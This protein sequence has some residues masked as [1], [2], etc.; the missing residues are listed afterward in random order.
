MGR[1]LAQLLGVFSS[2]TQIGRGKIHGGL[3][4]AA[5]Q[6]IQAHSKLVQIFLLDVLFSLRYLSSSQ[7]LTLGQDFPVCFKVQLGL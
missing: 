7:Q 3:E 2:L 1:R 5:F 4:P 6:W